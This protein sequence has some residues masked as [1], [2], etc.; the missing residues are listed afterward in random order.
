MP[1]LA[2]NIGERPRAITTQDAGIPALG[3]IVLPNNATAARLFE[4]HRFVSYSLERRG[5]A[6][7]AQNSSWKIWTRC[8]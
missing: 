3:A 2:Y 1:I 8:G 6:P 4:T 7:L 5:Y